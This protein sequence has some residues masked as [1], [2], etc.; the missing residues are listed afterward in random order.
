VNLPLI[1]FSVIFTEHLKVAYQVKFQGLIVARR[2][3]FLFPF[4]TSGGTSKM[5]GC[6]CFLF[7]TSGGTN[8][9]QDG[10][11]VSGPDSYNN[12]GSGGGFQVGD[13]SGITSHPMPYYGVPP[14]TKGTPLPSDFNKPPPVLNLDAGFGSKGNTDDGYQSS[15]RSFQGGDVSRDQFPDDSKKSRSESYGSGFSSLK[16]EEHGG[17]GRG[18][19]GGRW[20]PPSSKEQEPSWKLMSEGS[21]TPQPVRAPSKVC[22]LYHS[23]SLY[24]V[25]QTNFLF[26]YDIS[27]LKKEVTLSHPV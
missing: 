10:S 27:Y 6:F 23:C 14:P 4:R 24:R 3:M 22:G 2:P 8:K 16:G 15:K 13:R 1:S 9:M 21:A 17:R 18:S 26:L 5:Q 11:T 19:R 7:R 20:A 12:R 25:W